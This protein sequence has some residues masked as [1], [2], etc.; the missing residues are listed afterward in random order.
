[1]NCD[2]CTSYIEW[3][4]RHPLLARS[5]QKAADNTFIYQICPN[6]RA[7]VVVDG[8][9]CTYTGTI[10]A[11]TAAPKGPCRGVASNLGLHPYTCTACDALTHWKTSPLNQIVSRAPSLKHPRSDLMRATKPGVVHKFVSAETLE[12]AL[13]SQKLQSA[14]CQQK[15]GHLLEANHKLLSHSWHNSASIQPFVETFINPFEEKKL[16]TFD[17]SFLQNWL[18]KKQKG[19][20]AKADGQAR[21]LAILYS[22]RLGEKLYTTSAPMLGLPSVRQAWRI[23][24]KEIGDQYYLPGINGWTLDLASC[25]EPRP[26]QNGMDG[27]RIIR[28]VELYRDQFLVGKAFPR[29]V[30]CFPSAEQLD[31][32]VSWQ[33]VQEHVMAVREKNYMLLKHI[34]STCPTQQGSYLISSLAQ[35]QKVQMV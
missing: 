17:L 9:K 12:G 2:C 32:A 23:C 29:N 20:Y 13:Q 19:C 25:R 26:L 24:A 1:M 3:K 18:H 33:Q 4:N 27:T 28:V 16:S 22:N 11:S 21:K 8:M 10:R 5:L 34:P 7:T 31:E 15:M 30:H 6:E 35:F 14:I